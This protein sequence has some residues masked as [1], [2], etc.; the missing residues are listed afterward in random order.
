MERQLIPF[1]IVKDELNFQNWHPTV[2]EFTEA[3]LSRLEL[4]GNVKDKVLRE[5][6]EILSLC[7]PPS[8]KK[9]NENGLVIGFVQSG[10]T[11]SF[12]T[13]T[14]LARD[15]GYGLVVVLTGVTNIL[16]SQSTE[17]LTENLIPDEVSRDWKI[18]EN[19]GGIKGDV[20]NPDFQDLRQRLNSWSNQGNGRGLKKPSVIVTLLKKPSRIDSFSNLLSMLDLSEIPTLVID[21][22]SDQASPNTK[23]SQNLKRGTDDE[24]STYASIGTLL[25][26]FSKCTLL[27]YTATPQAN[28]LAAKLDALAPKFGFLLEPGD[29]YTGAETFFS[30]GSP[31]L[32][33]ISSDEEIRSRDLPE[34]PPATLEAAL[35]TYWLGCAYFLYAEKNLGHKPT[36][37]SMMVQVSQ[38]TNPQSLFRNWCSSIRSSYSS[39]LTGSNE[40][41]ANETMDYFAEAYEDLKKTVSN[42]PEFN[43]LMNF[44]PD[45]LDETKIVEVNSSDNAETEI[46]WKKSQFWILVGGMKLDRGFTVKGITVTYM[47][48]SVSE[49]ADT[50]QQRAR[51]FGYHAAYMGLCRIY[52]TDNLKNSF[53][54]YMEHENALRK[55]LAIHN[56]KDLS[57]WKRD[58]LLDS[59][60]SRLTRANVIG[61]RLS[62]SQISN[63]WVSPSFM[64]ENIDAVNSNLELFESFLKYLS[65]YHSIVENPVEWI[66]KRKNGKRHVLY[67]GVDL[68]V[69]QEFLANLKITNYKDS[70]LV[71]NLALAIDAAKD[72]GKKAD[73]VVINGLDSSGS[74]G[75]EVNQKHGLR[76]VFVGKNPNTDVISDLKY[77]GDSQIHRGN[78]TLHIRMVNIS[79]PE[80]RRTDSSDFI[81]PWVAFKATDEIS[82]TFIFEKDDDD[83]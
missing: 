61:R 58:F 70:A 21:D 17:R 7:T 49:N 40:A 37:H 32:S 74:R 81:V 54:D 47:P 28:L 71:M 57:K 38:E 52:L 60:L 8:T 63:G 20:S 67:G 26:Q 64:H 48:R 62:K 4:D 55:S 14:A 43:E 15:N 3:Y 24:S 66:D 82:R 22:E 23:T 30:E 12:T 76:N 10:K 36:T 11:L 9:Y 83:A 78:P 29:G 75:Y 5:S 72:E 6:V 27:Q 2:G 31:F 25:A 50:L 42:F 80:F 41:L 34:E 51:F 56:G 69:V 33:V 35:R 45:V 73:I 65:E 46:V 13:V 59:S 18:F 44:M 1:E 19:P 16:K 77:V 68:V 79:N 53:I 39:C